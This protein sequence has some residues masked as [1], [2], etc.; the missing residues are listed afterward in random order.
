MILLGLGSN[1][2]GRWGTPEMILTHTL[3]VLEA[4][5]I[6]IKQRSSWSVTKPYGVQNQA[7]F[8]N[9]VVSVT[10][11]KP[12]LSLL[13]VCQKVERL[14]GR[15]QGLIWGPRVL[16]ID[17]LAYHDVIIGKSDVARP[18]THNRAFILPH[19]GIVD[20]LFVL[21]PL[22]EIV[23]GWHHPVTGLTPLQMLQKLHSPNG[24]EALFSGK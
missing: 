22:V 5:G 9:G 21:Q 23:P 17:L 1:M 13:S 3:E 15:R 16:D 19:P 20:R 2:S 11:H 24:G 8:V 4:H 6:A 18:Q 7:D 10:T 12:P 14:A